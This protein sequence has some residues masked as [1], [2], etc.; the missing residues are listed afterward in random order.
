[1]IKSEQL[2]EQFIDMSKAIKRVRNLHI[3][4]PYCGKEP[5]C[6]KEPSCEIFCA[7]CL[8]DYPCPTIKALDGAQ[9]G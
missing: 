9:D 6:G 5:C 1:M 8:V 3:L 2:A 4:E 7:E